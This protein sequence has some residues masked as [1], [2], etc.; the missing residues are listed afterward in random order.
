MEIKLLINDK[1]K[2]FVAGRPKA[3]LIRQAISITA[4]MDMSDIQG[5]E[6][7]KIVDFTVEAYGGQFTRDDVYDG[8]YADELFDKMIETITEITGGTAKKTESKN[9]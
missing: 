4:G 9:E 1:E 6:L 8:V 3:R 2:T 5:D 7:D